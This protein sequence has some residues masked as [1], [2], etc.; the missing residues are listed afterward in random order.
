VAHVFMSYSRRD[1]DFVRHL[2]D[3]LIGQSREAWV[4]WKD[5]PLTAEWQQEILTN[6]ESS[7]NFI[8]VISPES[9]ASANCKSEIDHAVANH[10]RIFP[11]VRRPVRDDAVPQAVRAFQWIDF[12]EDDAFDQRFATLLTA[13]D[14]DLAWVN[15]HTRLLTRAK[16]WER[17]DKDKSFLLRGKDL[18]EAERWVAQCSAKNPKP[19]ILQ[20]QYVLASRQ[21]ATT[22]QRIVVGAIGLAFLVAVGLAVLAFVQ[23]NVAQRQTRIADANA[24]EAQ[25]QRA[26]AVE[27][28]NNAVNSE[29][30]A[31]RQQG[32]ALDN[33][34]YA[35]EQEGIAKEETAVAQRHERQSRAGELAAFSTDSLREDPERSVFLAMQAVN[36]TLRFGELPVSAAEQALHE[37]IWASRV[38]MTLRGESQFFGVAFSPD[39]KRVAASSYDHTAKIWD[40]KSGS[41][42]ITLTGHTGAV[43][44]VVF[45]A[46]GKRL[47]TAGDDETARVWDSVSGQNLLTL[48]G[49]TSLV[50]SVTFSRD[51]RYLATS[52]ADHSAKLWDALSGQELLTLRTES[53]DVAGIFIGVAISPDNKR[54]ATSSWDG[55]ATLWE[56]PSGKELLTLRGHT[57]GI[58]GSVNAI[59]FSPD[60][61]RL[62]TASSDNTAKVWDTNT[63]EELL[64]L[65]GHSG[66]VTS[67]AFSADGNRLATA[68]GDRTVKVN[69]KTVVNAPFCAFRSRARPARDVVPAGRRR[70]PLTTPS[71]CR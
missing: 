2:S 4:D 52:S 58:L 32:I 62:A 41:P 29:K 3:A 54:I 69:G 46:D 63:G 68:S 22:V 7:E 44:N 10:K 61:T 59:T 45:S 64:T 30:E 57:P 71:S 5:I 48:S 60:G 25:L 53:D 9:A 51:G 36:A 47:A 20:S 35:K 12:S 39:G 55:T 65:R 13:L 21:S 27:Q 11:I 6:I 17:E 28:K 38:R 33:E 23:R 26:V 67:V 56:M 34:R 24:I 19:T 50:W 1:M 70:A 66:S 16:E 37:S 31:K 42:L 8:F 43:M 14:T 49:H 15:A 18:R 40:A